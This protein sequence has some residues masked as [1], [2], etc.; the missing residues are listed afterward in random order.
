MS[1][2][3][4]SGNPF[5][6]PPS[7]PT[8]PLSPVSPR[9]NPWKPAAAGFG[10]A[11]LLGAGVFGVTRLATAGDDPADTAPVALAA[12]PATAVAPPATPAP[13]TTA[14]EPARPAPDSG[15]AR[16][17]HTPPPDLDAALDDVWRCLGVDPEELGIDEFLDDLI[18]R[19]D[20]LPHAPLP[21]PGRRGPGD[22]P[23]RLGPW[24]AGEVTI[25]VTGP[26]GLELYRLDGDGSVT[27][28]RDGDD[29]TVT[30]DGAAAETDLDEFVSEWLGALDLSGLPIPDLSDLPPLSIPDLTELDGDWQEWLEEWQEEW[31]D[32]APGPIGPMGPGLLEKFGGLGECLA[33][34]AG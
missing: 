29:V 23:G 31:G 21:G 25:T 2:Q 13:P 26:D 24:G 28:T 34:P 22:V 12:P 32:G 33:E 18:E 6:R 27:I 14:P 1:D 3:N 11:L 5:D 15:P 20:E 10:A 17:H 9:S 8:V 16:R 30:V 4:P 19:L 7:G